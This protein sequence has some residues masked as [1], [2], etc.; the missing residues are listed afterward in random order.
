VQYAMSD[1]ETRY[2]LRGIYLHTAE[3]K[4]RAVATDGH[5][6]AQHDG[7]STDDFAG[8]IVPRK[9][10]SMVPTGD[11][12]VGVS[13][14]KIR[15]LSDGLEI[16]SKVI[17]GTFPDYQRVIPRDNPKT[18]VVDRVALYSASDR[19]ATIS[20]EKTR[21]VK[22]SFAAGAV[23]L[24]ARGEV[25]TAEDEIGIEYD[26]E[27]L[28]IGFNAAYVRDTL[29]AFVDEKVTLHLNEPGSPAVIEAGGPLLA[30]L[31]PLRVA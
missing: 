22:F 20:S 21:S 14:R 18:A 26:A 31:M 28:D 25:G 24:S 27:P 7:P 8:V 30:V 10:V 13:S 12:S 1:E 6:L 23:S 5:R 11:I 3:G 4:L 9:L 29:G 15:F 16:V 2:F 17:D 19:V